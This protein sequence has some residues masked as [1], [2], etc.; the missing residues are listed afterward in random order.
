MPIG[1]RCVLRFA[2]VCVGC[3]DFLLCCAPP[4]FF[5]KFGL[6]SSANGF[7]S[8]TDISY[9]MLE[10]LNQYYQLKVGKSPLANTVLI[11]DEVD[12][13]IVD[14]QP[15]TYYLYP[16]AIKSANFQKMCDAFKDG[17]A[18]T[19]PDSE[20]KDEFAEVFEKASAA[21]A[22]GRNKPGGYA[23]SQGRHYLINEANEWSA[24]YSK[25]GEYLDYVA[26]KKAPKLKT[27]YYCVCTAHMLKQYEAIIGLSGSLGSPAEV[28]YL[29]EIY[30]AASIACPPFLDTCVGVTK[31]LPVLVD[32]CVQ[33]HPTAAAA[34]H[35]VV[36]LATRHAACVPVVVLCRNAVAARRTFAAFAASVGV[37][38]FLEYGDDNERMNYSAVVERATL[39]VVN[40]RAGSK[41]W[42]IT[43]TDSF[44]GRGQDYRV[45]DRDVDD[46]GGLLVI[47]THMPESEREWIQWKGRTARTD[48]RGQYAVVLDASAEPDMLAPTK[49]AEHALTDSASPRTKY[50]PALLAQLLSERDGLVKEKLAENKEELVRGLR[51]NE[52]CDKFWTQQGGVS[53]KW[54]SNAGQAALRTYLAETAFDASMDDVAEAAVAV[55]LV[56]RK[57]RSKH[58]SCFAVHAF[59]ARAHSDNSSPSTDA[60]VPCCSLTCGVLRRTCTSLPQNTQS[61]ELRRIILIILCG[62]MRRQR[63]ECTTQP[64]QVLNAYT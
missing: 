44:G 56:K 22:A 24:T 6:T 55:G 29:K 26:S 28:A 23:L 51:N 21:L 35:A 18:D 5:T 7:S 9:C 38:L 40:E 13:L 54:P 63:Q 2:V 1:L 36:A 37:Q 50:R 3:T 64:H 48:R 46:A 62:G 20:E 58:G 30:G 53:A 33:V 57:A 16:D 52:L 15:T 11:V 19:I 8:D 61:D 43:V 12:A 4:Q 59:V 39:P 49:L 27:K 31:A 41:R 45:S 34:D 25:E 10:D 47:A 17:L 60:R 42:P 32:N 14:R